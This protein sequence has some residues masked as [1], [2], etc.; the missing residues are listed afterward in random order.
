MLEQTTYN[1]QNKCINGYRTCSVSHGI[2]M[3]N[4]KQALV[5]EGVRIY[6]NESVASLSHKY[7]TAYDYTHMPWRQK[8]QTM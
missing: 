6:E 4:A 2:Y 5:P 3:T 8:K 7:A 1:Q